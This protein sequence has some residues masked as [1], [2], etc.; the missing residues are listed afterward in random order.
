MN[1]E[2]QTKTIEAFS[3]VL[4]KLAFMF[5]EPVE[6]GESGERPEEA[7]QA[8]VTFSGPLH[9]RLSVAVPREWCS[10]L[11]ANILGVDEG[12]DAALENLTDALKELVNVTCGHVLTAVA[13]EQLQFDLSPPEVNELSEDDWGRLREDSET[14]PM[15]IDEMSP[16]LLHFEVA[17]SK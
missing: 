6:R 16:A 12:D 2:N 8:E 13:G 3:Q 15:I 14:I 9:G 10:E 7:L 1:S 5:A 4:G 11:A 17:E